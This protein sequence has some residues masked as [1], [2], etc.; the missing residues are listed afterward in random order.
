MVK[1][2]IKAYKFRL[3]P[4]K[5]QEVFFA[6]QFGC[7]SATCKGLILNC[8]DAERRRETRYSVTGFLPR[9]ASTVTTLYEARGTTYRRRQ[10]LLRKS[11]QTQALEVQSGVGLGMLTWIK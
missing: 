3:Y 9:H 7:C 11:D 2:Y 1:S 4:N 10:R 8:F 6:R 5:Q